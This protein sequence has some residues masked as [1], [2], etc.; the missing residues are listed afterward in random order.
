VAVAALARSVADGAAAL[1]T[2]GAAEAVSAGI[3]AHSCDDDV[4]A[5]GEEALK[6]LGRAG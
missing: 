2:A 5:A 6:L 3:G 4:R 1:V